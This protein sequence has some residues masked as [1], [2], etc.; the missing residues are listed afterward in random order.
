MKP[1]PDAKEISPATVIF[2]I[3]LEFVPSFVKG[4]YHGLGLQN[5]IQNPFPVKNK[6]LSGS[7][8]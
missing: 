1:Q 6:L 5:L 7:K 2:L 3:F 4:N 8:F